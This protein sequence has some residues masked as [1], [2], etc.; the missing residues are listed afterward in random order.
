MAR[1]KS[2]ETGPVIEAGFRIRPRRLPSGATVWQVDLGQRNGRRRRKQ[3]RT[4]TAARAYARHLAIE[5]ERVGLAA[6]TLDDK[7]RQDAARALEILRGTGATLTAAAQE[8]VQ[9]HGRADSSVTVA[10]LVEAFLDWM[11]RTSRKLNARAP[12]PYRA[13]TIRTTTRELQ[14]LARDLGGEPAATVTPETLRGWLDSLPVGPV[15]WAALHRHA[16]LLYTWASRPGG[17]LAGLPNPA[18]GLTPPAAPRVLP[19]ILTPDQVERV[20][21]YVERHASRRA[22]VTLA[23]GFFSGIR[24]YE[25]SRLFPSALDFAAGEIEVPPEASKTHTAR[26][27]TMPDNL[28]AWLRRYPPPRGKPLGL[29]EP[30]MYRIRRLV[31]LATGVT[32]SKDVARHSYATYTAALHGMDF[33]AEQLGHTGTAVLHRHYRGLARN[34]RAAAEKY[35]SILP[36]EPAQPAGLRLVAGPEV[37]QSSEA[38]RD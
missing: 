35:F 22:V 1:R 36:S 28:K 21:R 26:L 30:A 37:A 13:A 8:Y 20:L 25:L 33:A 17:P 32:L 16:R 15:S 5:R 2:P 6:F 29:S 10:E 34:R 12:G 4:I 3:F 24:P 11:A 18:A 31:R 9:R 23:L 19:E 7:A 38:C 27:V 14:R